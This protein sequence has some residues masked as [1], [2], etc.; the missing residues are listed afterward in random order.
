MKK[1]PPRWLVERAYQ[2]DV[3]A[4]EDLDN[5][6]FCGDF[7]EIPQSQECCHEG[8]GKPENVKIVGIMYH[9]EDH[10]GIGQCSKCGRIFW[11]QVRV[12]N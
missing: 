8:I 6:I 1:E 10:H 4:G 9:G 7:L 12:L 2:V 11:L 3:D 5:W